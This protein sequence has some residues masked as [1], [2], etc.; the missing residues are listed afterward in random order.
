[1][2]D[3]S[4]GVKVEVVQ[5]PDLAQ[6]L[7]DYASVGLRLARQRQI[8]FAAGVALAAY[9]Y[10]FTIAIVSLSLIVCSEIYDYITFRQIIAWSGQGRFTARW[11][12][13]KLLF[14]TVL[15]C[16]VIVYYSVATAFLQG[17]GPHFI[18]L[19]FL[20]AAGLFAAMHNHQVKVI[21]VLR[22]VVYGIA[23]LFIPIW[24]IVATGASFTSE[25]WAN[26]LVSVF[27]LHFVVEC[28]RN[29]LSIYI[30][31][32]KQM[33]ALAIETRIANEAV[34]AKGE[35]LSTM[36]HELRTPLTS[37]KG[38]IDLMSAGKLGSMPDNVKK[39]LA[40]A[41]RNCDRLVRLVD[42][43]LD[44]HKI[45]AG[46]MSFS[47]DVINLKKLVESTL[48]AN[49]PFAE[50]L[51]IVLNS[52]GVADD[53]FVVGDWVRLEQV[54]TNILSNAAKFSPK[55][56][57]VKIKIEMGQ[58]TAR[59]LV[60]D[61]GIGL[62][63][64][65]KAAVFDRYSKVNTVGTKLVGGTGIG[66]NI[67]EK[68]MHAHDGQITTIKTKMWER[69]S[70][71]S[72]QCVYHKPALQKKWRALK[73]KK[74]AQQHN[75]LSNLRQLCVWQKKE[76]SEQIER[77]FSPTIWCKN[78]TEPMFGKL[79]PAGLNEILF[80]DLSCLSRRA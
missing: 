54:M 38:S 21:L 1:M 14:G 3:V 25:L 33:A 27:A 55:G 51:G 77:D 4:E 80:I 10:S 26:L 64:N 36:S 11:H 23:F 22:V 44:L 72:C 13:T 6:N 50:R 24:D 17:P 28:S 69:H 52:E 67:S 43:T 5:G 8:S 39:V 71:W 59:I 58:G 74:Q 60:I 34:A 7:K 47:M 20:L 40:I 42:D 53:V 65:E 70:L 35:F 73:R 79:S 48:A 62:S 56:S 75:G 19:F 32:Q 2:L 29:Y 63:E 30:A 49:Q 76:L 16:V 46:K 41:Q 31:N 61:R 68:I 66:M 9:Y 57:E 15:S 45:L 78:A 18:S 12:L 37:I